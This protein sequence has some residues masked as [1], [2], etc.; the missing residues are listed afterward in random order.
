[1][2]AHDEGLVAATGARHLRVDVGHRLAVVGDVLELRGEPG[3]VEQAGHMVGDVVE[4]ALGIVAVAGERH[5]SLHGGPRPVTVDGGHHRRDVREHLGRVD[6]EL[7][8]CH[9][10]GRHGAVQRVE[11]G[12]CRVVRVG[13]A[14]NGL[15]Y[16]AGGEQG[17]R[18]GATGEGPVQ[19]HPCIVPDRSLLVWRPA[20]GAVVDTSCKP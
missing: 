3:V 14:R 16:G 12:V 5:E 2:G 13:R 6:A 1:M 9:H 18:G 10:E 20:T 19:S 11:H 7:V 4:I 15:R 8:R 17:E